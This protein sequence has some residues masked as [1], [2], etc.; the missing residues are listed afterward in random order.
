[1]L[2]NTETNQSIYYG[3][4]DWR[5]VRFH[6]PNGATWFAVA[7]QQVTGNHTL[8]VNGQPAGRLQGL[9]MPL[10]AGRNGVMVVSS[11]DLLGP[12]SA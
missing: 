4:A 11:D 10:G 8:M 5:A 9:G 3:S 2:V 12:S 7:T 6:L 1:V